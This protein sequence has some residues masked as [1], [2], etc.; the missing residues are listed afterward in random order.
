MGVLKNLQQAQ[1][2]QGGLLSQVQQQSTI[3]HGGVPLSLGG[4]ILQGAGNI[5]QSIAQPFASLAA[6]P[7]Q[8]IAKV[9]GQEDPYAN[10]LPGF[11][12]TTI[13]V[14]PL[15]AE[16]KAGDLLKAG[17]ETAAVATAPA[18]LTGMIGT[19]ALVGGAHGAGEAM[20]QEKSASEVVKSGGIGATIGALTAGV[21][22]GFGKLIGK[23]GDKIQTSV[24]RPTSHDLRDGFSL[25]TI[26]QYNLGGNLNTTLSKTQ[27]KLDDLSTQLNAKLANSP[28]RVD[29]SKIYAETMDDLVNKNKFKGFST[30]TKIQGALDDLGGEIGVVGNELSIPEAQLVKQ[31]AGRSGA[32]EYGKVDPEAK[33]R[34]LVYTTFYNKLKTQI[35]KSSPEGVREIN[36]EISKL[37]PVSNAVLRRIPVAERNNLISLTDMI[38][39]VGSTVNP[40]SLGITLTNLIS[41]SGTAGNLLSKVSQPIQKTAIPGALGASTIGQ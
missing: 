37:I 34:E 12:G 30:N 9:T 32:W 38:G 8:A 27:S 24:I 10:G 21:I 1:Q 5:A 39:L 11:G 33:A 2:P 36:K 13:P 23:I 4:K 31:A 16:A 20:Q 15:S 3:S 40:A 35:E 7:V 26:K 17:A 19:G 29:L 28:E 25:D 41:K 14:S 22:G 18:T 6:T